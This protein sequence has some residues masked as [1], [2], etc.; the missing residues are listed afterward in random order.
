MTGTLTFF[1]CTNVPLLTHR[2]KSG[3]WAGSGNKIR[4]NILKREVQNGSYYKKTGESRVGGHT[5][6]V[7]RWWPH[8]PSPPVATPPKEAQTQKKLLSKAEVL[9]RIVILKK[10]IRKTPCAQKVYDQL[11]EKYG[12]DLR[13]WIAKNKKL[14]AQEY[15]FDIIQFLE[16][17]KHFPGK[18]KFYEGLCK[19]YG[20]S[21]LTGPL[22]SHY[23]A[24]VKSMN[25]FK[26][27]KSQWSKTSQKAILEAKKGR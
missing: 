18:L 3:L 6:Q 11:S 4:G 20:W 24:I 13:S 25:W 23:Q 21:L 14:P 10:Q 17:A 27:K 12:E 16:R 9:N 19:K 22:P 2:E 26:N 7:R 8:R 1:Q 5:G 15:S